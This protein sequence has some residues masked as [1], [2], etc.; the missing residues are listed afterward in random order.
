[1]GIDEAI[2]KKLKLIITKCAY[3]DFARRP[4]KSGVPHKKHIPG[5]EIKKIRDRIYKGKYPGLDKEIKKIAKDYVALFNNLEEKPVLVAAG[6]PENW[7]ANIDEVSGL[8]TAISHHADELLESLS[9]EVLFPPL[10]FGISGGQLKVRLRP[11]G[12]IVT[13]VTSDL[14]G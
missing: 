4:L 1:M 12:F 10:R 2:W 9:V 11:T 3:I 7:L 14:D 6:D 13:H 5:S 8:P